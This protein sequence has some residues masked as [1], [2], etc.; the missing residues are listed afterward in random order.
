M[1]QR[2]NINLWRVHRRG[3]WLV[4]C[5]VVLAIFIVV[6]VG[7][8][9][10]VA[11]NAR[12]W[13]ADGMD[14][15]ITAMVEEAPINEA[16]KAET[17]KV[18]EGFVQEFR[19]KKITLAQLGQIMEELPKSAVLPAGVAM[20]IGRAYFE[21]S[22]LSDEEKAD[23]QQQLARIAHGIGGGTLEQSDL[24][25]VLQPL[26]AK[27]TETNAFV[28]NLPDNSSIRIK[29]PDAVE[30]DELRAFIESVRSK[31]DER[32]LPPEPPEFDLSGELQKMIDV[33]LG[34]YE[35]DNHSDEDHGD[36]D[37]DDSTDSEPDG[38]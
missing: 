16:E 33:A 35:A 1:S 8:G 32:E 6:L 30:D 7:L 4:G 17:L 15:M 14:S 18:V 37:H 3:N 19:D 27:A 13:A 38:P 5:G 24:I 11:M 31:A 23:G 2:T 28:L 29:N 36:H 10:F 21:E 26:K 22:G 34:R 25:E 12:S 9:V 20:G